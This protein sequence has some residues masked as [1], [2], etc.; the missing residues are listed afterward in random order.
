MNHKIATPYPPSQ[1]FLLL[2]APGDGPDW[3]ERVDNERLFADL[4]REQ[5]PEAITAFAWLW[6]G[7]IEELEAETVFGG[8]DDLAKYYLTTFTG[9]RTGLVA[10]IG[11]DT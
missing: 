1:V 8:K 4:L 9:T 11:W 2:V 6:D 7:S 5:G 3:L 10:Q